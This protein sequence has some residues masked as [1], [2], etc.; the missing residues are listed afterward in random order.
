MM[1]TLTTGDIGARVVTAMGTGTD[2]ARDII[3]D[4]GMP[5][6]QIGRWVVPG[7]IVVPNQHTQVVEISTEIE[8]QESEVREEHIPRVLPQIELLQ[9][10]LKD[11]VRLTMS[12]QIDQEMFTD[13]R[14]M[15]AGSKGI[16]VQDSGKVELL[17]EILV[18]APDLDL[19]QVRKIEVQHSQILAGNTICVIEVLPDQVT[20]TNI[21]RGQAQEPRL[22][23]RVQRHLPLEKEIDRNKSKL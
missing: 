8:L 9:L 22:K 10:F 19:P 1:R 17:R 20:I 2:I 5:L 23:D 6:I 7:R 14:K 18:K 13:G 11:R 21:S 15:V 3:L 4:I 12:I 16:I